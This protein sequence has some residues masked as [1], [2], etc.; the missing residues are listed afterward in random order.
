MKKNLK[1]T[2]FMIVA[3]APVGAVQAAASIY[4]DLATQQQSRQ[5][6]PASAP[7]GAQGPIR[8]DAPL[9]VMP[10]AG[11]MYDSLKIFQDSQRKRTSRGATVQE[12]PQMQREGEGS[13]GY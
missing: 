2:T 11:N 12:A 13:T 3:L 7:R 10:A 9:A 6:A 4:D 5:E 1:L 8:T